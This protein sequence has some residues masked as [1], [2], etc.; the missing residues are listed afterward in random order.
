MKLAEVKQM[1][2]LSPYD[3]AIQVLKFG[4]ELGAKKRKPIKK[5]Y[6]PRALR[7]EAIGI[8]NSAIQHLH[9]I[10]EES[11]HKVSGLREEGFLES[12]LGEIQNLVFTPQGRK[13]QASQALRKK[14]KEPVES[15]AIRQ[16]A[17]G[18]LDNAPI[19]RLCSAYAYWQATGADYAAIPVLTNGLQS[20]DE[21]QFLLSA[22]CLYKIKP[23][24][25]SAYIGTKEDDIFEKQKKARDPQS[26]TVMIH[27]TFARDESWYQP[28]G[29]FHTYVKQN[30]YPDLY[31]ESDFYFWSG[32]YSGNARRNAAT[33]LVEWCN[34]H[35]ADMYRFISHSH[36]ANV[37]NL[38]TRRGLQACTL[39]HLSPPVHPQYMPDINNVSSS[40]FFTIRPKKDWV[41]WLDGGEQDYHGT[42][43]EQYE[44]RKIIARFGHSKSHE[45]DKWIS[46]NVGQFVK[47]VC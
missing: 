31:D 10:A 3:R 35:P 34:A 2:D 21:E 8:A 45:P 44:N 38:A 18:M 33:K 17:L 5:G 9:G 28:G 27:G 20:E 37:V 23:K 39:I 1:V 46:K 16:L 19:P 42:P 43:V 36:G 7:K 22:H 47:V 13:L 4:A 40:T 30:V 32:R 11:L 24:L 41:I 12:T 15:L 25:V 29:D 26:L 14:G 6:M